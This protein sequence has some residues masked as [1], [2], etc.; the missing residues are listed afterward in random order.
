MQVPEQKW[1]SER[2]PNR[3]S[4]FPAKKKKKKKDGAFLFASSAHHDYSLM[5]VSHR[6]L[7][8]IAGAAQWVMKSLC[9]CGFSAQTSRRDPSETGMNRNCWYFF[10][11]F[12]SYCFYFVCLF[13]YINLHGVFFFFFFNLNGALREGNFLYICWELRKPLTKSWFWRIDKRTLEYVSDV[14]YIGKIVSKCKSCKV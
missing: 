1:K 3:N 9:C 13:F 5:P 11:F 4:T 14:C 10:L 12:L 2:R 7:L 6:A 8:T